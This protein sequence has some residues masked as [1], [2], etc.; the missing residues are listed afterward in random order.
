MKILKNFLWSNIPVAMDA[1]AWTLLT[2]DVFGYRI[3]GYMIFLSFGFTWMYYTYDRLH[4]SVSDRINNPERS[5]WYESK[6]YLIYLVYAVALC[7]FFVL[8]KHK[9]L[10]WPILIG[11]VPCILYAKS[12][13]IGGKTYSVKKIPGM[14]VVLVA[15]LWVLMTIYIPL[16][17]EKHVSVLSL[18]VSGYSIL[19]F[20]Y[21]CILI[22]MNDLLDVEGDRKLNIRTIP[23]LVGEKNTRI[24]C[25]IFI[26]VAFGLGLYYFTFW[27]LIFYSSFLAI[28]TLYYTKKWFLYWQNPVSLPAVAAYLILR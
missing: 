9:S 5:G 17:N 3:N 11:S 23:V 10:L 19:I 21:A 25:F 15:F 1:A 27:S 28:R 13:T 7:L 22:T 20:I 16:I 24:A 26:S 14:K 8:I 2:Y 6:K 18:R 12:F 4:I